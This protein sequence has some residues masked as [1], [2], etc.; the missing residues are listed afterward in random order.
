M[1][2]A[3]DRSGELPYAVYSDGAANMTGRR[4]R[5]PKEILRVKRG[6]VGCAAGGDAGKH[7]IESADGRSNPCCR[8]PSFVEQPA[9]NSWLLGDLVLQMHGLFLSIPGYL[10]SGR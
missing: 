2:S 6:V 9:N 5:A 10:S 8:G 1:T 3:L 4:S 7:R